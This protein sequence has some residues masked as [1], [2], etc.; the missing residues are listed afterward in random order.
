MCHAKQIPVL[1][2][3]TIVHARFALTCL[4]CQQMEYRAWQCLTHERIQFGSVPMLLVGHYSW[5]AQPEFHSHAM[6]KKSSANKNQ[7]RKGSAQVNC[8][9]AV[10]IVGLLRLLVIPG[11][12]HTG[13]ATHFHLMGLPKGKRMLARKKKNGKKLH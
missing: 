13:L 11:N 1:Y 12:A 5:S 7:N 8:K 2:I 10:S 9:R 3:R 6:S 4:L